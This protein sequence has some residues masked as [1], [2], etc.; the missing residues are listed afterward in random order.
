[1]TGGEGTYE[2]SFSH[3]D[4]VPDNVQRTLAEKH[5]QHIHHQDEQ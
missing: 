2:I 5:Q 1:M 3:Y 4:P